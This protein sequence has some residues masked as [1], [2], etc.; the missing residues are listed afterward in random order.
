MESAAPS[1]TAARRRG[2]V[3][4]TNA[5]SDSNVLIVQRKMLM[6]TAAKTW[7]SFECQTA[8]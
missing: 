5:G 7:L 3:G 6:S 4:A 1:A 8:G 2:F